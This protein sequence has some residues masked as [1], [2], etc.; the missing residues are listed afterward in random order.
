MSGEL[1]GNVSIGEFI[2]TTP[3][4]K[5]TDL[6]TE[7]G[8]K[9]DESGGTSVC[10]FDGK[11][12]VNQPAQN[13]SLDQSV[14]LL[15]GMAAR[16]DRLHGIKREENLSANQFVRQF[17]LASHE[18]ANISLVKLFNGMQGNRF[19]LAGVVAPDTGDSDSHP[20]LRADGPGYCSSQGFQ[21]THWHPFVDGVFVPDGAGVATQIDSAGHSVDLPSTTGR[22]WGPLWSRSRV[23]NATA[24]G[25]SE[26]YWGAGSLEQVA[27]RLEQCKDGMIGSHAN[28]GVTFDL[29]AVR[30][31]FEISPTEFTTS[32][33]NLHSARKRSPQWA[34]K[35]RFNADL[36]VFIDGVL[37]GSCI[38]FSDQDG[39]LSLTIELSSQDRYLT[40]VTTNAGEEEPHSP[41]S[42][43]HVV[44]IDPVITGIDLY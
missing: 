31:H 27:V 22:T 17:P 3:T 16:I 40:L 1:T 23:D 20:W 10:V 2:L 21:P 25:S 15:E 43:D 38:D 36:R 11:V 19:R 14:L 26:D 18:Q 39:E 42:N 34:S 33:A 6:G 13:Q 32:I 24:T 41:D 5:V 37:R 30:T 29:D 9:L 4:A 8:V 12:R 7:F 44:L 28:V 35:Y